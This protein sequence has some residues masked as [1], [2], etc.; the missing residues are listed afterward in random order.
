MKFSLSVKVSKSKIKIQKSAHMSERGI[1]EK[2][3]SWRTEA[4]DE[5]L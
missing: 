1:T 2:I 4:R 3:I 5:R